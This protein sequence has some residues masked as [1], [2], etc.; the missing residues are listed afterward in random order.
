MGTTKTSDLCFEI[1]I[2]KKRNQFRAGNESECN[3]W[4]ERIQ[5]ASKLKIKDIYRFDAILGSNASGTTKVLSAKHRVTGEEVAVKVISKKEYNPKMLSN[6]VL[7]LKR[8]DHPHVV[9]LFDLFETRKNVYLVME[10][11]NGGELF[12]QIANLKGGG[13]FTEKECI[14]VLHQIA[15]AV[16]Y[17]HSMGIVHRDLKPENILCVYPHSAKEIKIADFGI[18]KVIFDPEI[19]KKEKQK[20]RKEQKQKKKEL[21]TLQQRSLELYNQQSTE[22]EED[23]KE[24]MTASSKYQ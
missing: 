23:F 17:M 5:R 1:L 10:K 6:E 11:C 18:S 9:K 20:F 24:E 12:E 8:L 16:K 21:R 4:T 22:N 19:R 15:K 14:T 2:R 3:S 13:G 7:I